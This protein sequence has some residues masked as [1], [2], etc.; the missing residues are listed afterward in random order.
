MV[1][2]VHAALLK[3]Q[4]PS[5]YSPLKEAFR[6]QQDSSNLSRSVALLNLAL[7]LTLSLAKKVHQ[8]AS[9]PLCFAKLYSYLASPCL[10]LSHFFL[11]CC[12]SSSSFSCNSNSNSN[13]FSSNFLLLRFLGL[14]WLRTKLIT[15]DEWLTTR[16]MC[17]TA[18][19]N[20]QTQFCSPNYY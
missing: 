15:T 10:S 13:F 9:V 2:K 3:K 8:R 18:N 19:C 4:E 14:A 16:V 17:Y 11:K 6:A 20:L 5:P 1:E 12:F 7:S